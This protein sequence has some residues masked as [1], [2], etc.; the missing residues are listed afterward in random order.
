MGKREESKSLVFLIQFIEA[1]NIELFLL[2]SHDIL[3]TVWVQWYAKYEGVYFLWLKS[4][5]KGFD[6]FSKTEG[7]RWLVVYSR[8]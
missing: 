7:V 3:M 2:S 4:V 8:L 1:D 5:F 6:S